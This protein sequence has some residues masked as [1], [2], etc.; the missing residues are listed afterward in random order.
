MAMKAC[1]G[2]GHRTVLANIEDSLLST[3]LKAVEEDCEI[4]YTGAMGD[5]DAQFSASVRRVKASFPHIKLI[6]VKPY[7]S[8]DINTNKEY[9]AELY[10][11]IIIP[12]EIIGI[13]YKAAIKARNRW[14][15]DNSDLII[16]YI[17][18]NYGGAAD[19]VKYARHKEKR[20]INP[21]D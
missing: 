5:F 14:M 12:P 15:V 8:N 10:D 18:R 3:V 1:C 9:Y 4:F 7:F 21:A 16:C 2:F 6:C 19:A 13:H 17:I 20:I 11:D